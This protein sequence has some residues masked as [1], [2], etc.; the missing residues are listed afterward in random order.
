VADYRSL[1]ILGHANANITLSYYAGYVKD[2]LSEM[3]GSV[4]S[5][6]EG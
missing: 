2:D 4:A 3:V 5:Q 6:I 1:E